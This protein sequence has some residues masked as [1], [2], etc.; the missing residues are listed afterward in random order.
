M[1]NLIR[2]ITPLQIIVIAAMIILAATIVFGAHHGLFIASIVPLTLDGLEAVAIDLKQK[3]SDVVSLG[4][5]LKQMQIE[6][7]SKLEGQEK[8]SVSLKEQIDLALTKFNGLPEQ[9]KELE[10]RMVQA[11][12]EPDRE[13]SWGEQFVEG[14]AYK[15]AI[16][17]GS[18]GSNRFS[19]GHSVKQVTSTEAGGMI[20]SLRETEVVNLLRERRVMRDLLR[21]IPINTSSVDYPVQSTRTN[22][23]APVAE[24]AAKPYSE[25]AWSSATVVVR[26][27]AHL[28]KITRQAMDDAPRLMGEIDA[29]LRY[30]L[31][32]IEERQFLYGD[33]T[34]QNL[35]GIVP[36]AAAWAA[37][38]GYADSMAT[39][40]D[41]LRLAALQASL[42]LLPADGMV[43]N[44]TDWALIELTK[45][46]NGD[47]IFARP[48]GTVSPS[49]WGL[50]VVVTPAMIL[51]DFLVGP[52]K[53]GA[54]VYDRMG[55]EVLISTENDKDFE[56]NLA[57]IRAEERVALAVKRPD[58]FITGTF[59]D[60]IA[61]L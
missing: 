56:N 2:N 58:N 6:I 55:V 21:T 25:Y 32:Y 61:A 54:T 48:Q 12:K 10:Q 40:L 50:P 33:N 38:V 3:Q 60:A 47:Y 41:V 59:D 5:S 57:T 14:A 42:T 36:Q 17:A 52:F 11:K 19:I 1:R 53:L 16:N 23:A 51:G 20:R 22:N 9:I 49:M 29:E 27:I 35:N 43:L 7:K 8:V 15:S 30:G 37:P 18:F 39:R 46:A 44:E 31:G 26:T 24:A 28:A 34:G 13:K 45:N 4:D